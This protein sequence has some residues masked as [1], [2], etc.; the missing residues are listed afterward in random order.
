MGCHCKVVLLH[1]HM[2]LFYIYNG[3][4]LSVHM[5]ADELHPYIYIKKTHMDVVMNIFLE[6][7]NINFLPF[8]CLFSSKHLRKVEC[9]C[10]LG[11]C[12]PQPQLCVLRHARKPCCPHEPRCSWW[13]SVQ[14]LALRICLRDCSPCFVF[15]MTVNSVIWQMFKKT[16]LPRN[17]V[18]LKHWSHFDLLHNEVIR[19]F[20]ILCA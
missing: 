11:E 18:L 6:T 15:G 14:I 3:C 7:K 1:I 4:N 12:W 20:E 2:W 17:I 9:R 16:P 19:G 8:Y 10:M 5:C 13:C